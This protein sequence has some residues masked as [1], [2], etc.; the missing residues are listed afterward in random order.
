MLRNIQRAGTSLFLASILLLALSS[1]AN[2]E[3]TDGLISYWPFDGNG[4][5]ASP[6]G[7]DLTL[8]GGVGFATGL[9]GESLDMHKNQNTYAQRLVDDAAYDFGSSDF[10][11][12]VWVNYYS[13][14]TEQ[15]LIEKFTGANGPGWTLTKRSEQWVQFYPVVTSPPQTMTTGS[16]HHILARRTGNQFGVWRDGAMIASGSVGTI[17]DSTTSLYIGRRNPADRRDFSMNGRLDEVAIWNRS[18]SDSEIAH[19]YNGGVGNPI[20]PTQPVPGDFNDDRM[21][22]AAD[23]VVWRDGQGAPYNEDDYD[24]WRASFGYP[25]TSSPPDPPQPRVLRWEIEA[26][27][28]EIHD[29]DNIFAN[30]R[31]GD[32]VRG[33]IRYDLN[34][35]PDSADPHDVLYQHDPT[36][37]VAGMVI[38]NPRD[39]TEL[40]F[41]P[42]HELFANVE[43]INDLEDEVFGEFD[44]VTAYQSV[45]PPEGSSGIAPNVVVDLFGPADVLAG[46]GLPVE[47]DLDDWP[48][49]SIL[50][51]DLG[52]LTG[53]GEPASYVFAE[54]HTLTPLVSPGSASGSAAHAA[55]PE[56]SGATLML[57]GGIALFASS[58]AMTLRRGA[59]VILAS[60]KPRAW[61]PTFNVSIPSAFFQISI[62]LILTALVNVLSA[63]AEPLLNP[64]T[65]HWYD[66]VTA[67]DITWNNAKAAA[68]STPYINDVGLPVA[69]YL[70]TI[71]S[72]VEESF[73]KTHFGDNAL[74]WIGASD[75]EVEGEWRWVTGPEAAADD[76]RGLLFWIGGRNGTAFGYENWID[77]VEP[78]ALGAGED[79]IDWNHNRTGQW[80]DV[81]A[82]TPRDVISG[83]FVEFG[84]SVSSGSGDFNNDGVVD[85][86]DYVVWRDGFGTTYIPDD[87]DV[88][89]AQFSAGATSNVSQAS[90]SAPA[91][92]EPPVFVSAP[93]MLLGLGL[94]TTYYVLSRRAP[95]RQTFKDHTAC[96]A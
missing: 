16:W 25:P 19:L 1:Q 58:R 54:I 89:R 47:L 67:Q 79:F 10:T 73:L 52:D 77:G 14:S 42:D 33:F 93:L 45:L 92:P 78:N 91:V 35:P 20:L 28:T 66:F 53:S 43:V 11:V 40:K 6:F 85:A 46:T 18:L 48:D 27:V 49:A 62:C 9:F 56:P 2:A 7:R 38:E 15:V 26:T 83:Y 22:D 94:R 61:E 80:N 71:T 88:W 36:F 37:E 63:N 39:G 96:H 34:T 75:A 41:L 21:V 32:P 50:F 3:L 81:A 90:G 13:T 4:S 55:V 24:A 60:W 29:P 51:I 69:G 74:V 86:A 8:Q 5:D 68:E 12:Q 65:G 17:S 70:A 82:N 23:Y 30:V 95:S 31:L 87:Y 59:N 84:G 57:F 64:D 76:G 72:D 44:N